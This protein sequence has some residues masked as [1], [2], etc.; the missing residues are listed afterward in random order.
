M[1]LVISTICVSSIDAMEKD[2][3]SEK[4]LSC[5]QSVLIATHDYGD[6]RLENLNRLFRKEN[7][8]SFLESDGLGQSLETTPLN[9]RNII[10]TLMFFDH[11][12]GKKIDLYPSGSGAEVLYQNGTK[13]WVKQLNSD[14][15][16]ITTFDKKDGKHKII[17]P[18]NGRVLVEKDNVRKICVA[19]D[20]KKASFYYRNL[21]V[22]TIDPKNGKV[23]LKRS[24]L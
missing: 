16:V 9:I 20:G 19:P 13:V 8:N 15:I 12:Q 5:S 21:E 23:L 22:E 24:Y 6:E 7:F 4:F 1:L 18:K 10:R 11:L 14:K 2:E 17:D 3:I